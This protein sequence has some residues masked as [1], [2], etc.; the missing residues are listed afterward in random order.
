MDKT[1]ERILV[2]QG[3]GVLGIMGFMA[4]NQ[5]MPALITLCVSFAVSAT[6]AAVGPAA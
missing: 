5:H 1:I 2:S 3:F 4:F 6:M